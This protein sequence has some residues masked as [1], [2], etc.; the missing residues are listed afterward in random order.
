[1]GAQWVWGGGE[2]DGGFACAMAAAEEAA[3]G[4]IFTTGSLAEG[5]TDGEAAGT[6]ARSADARESA[7][8]NAF[9]T[10][11]DE[12]GFAGGRK[13]KGSAPKPSWAPSVNSSTFSKP[14]EASADKRVSLAIGRRN[15]ISRK[16]SRPLGRTFIGGTSLRS[17]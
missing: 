11:A 1:M 16:T 10:G 2:E 4:E 15:V 5:A 12:G 8:E 3:D 6:P 13:G 7:F 14:I 9:G 17:D